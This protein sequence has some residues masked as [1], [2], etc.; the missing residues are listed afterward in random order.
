MKVAR[1]F[2]YGPP[3]TVQLVDVPRPEP[4][5][6]E[7]L[8][9]IHAA[10]VSSA[11]WRLRSGSIPRGF[12]TITRLVFGLRRL[13][14]PILGTEFSGT[15]WSLG[16]GAR[17]F[18]VGDP[19]IGFPGSEF[20]SHAEF[21]LMREDGRLVPKPAA[22][23]HPKAAALCF[24]GTT[25]LHY[26]RDRARLQAGQS[27]L[28]LGGAGSVGS[29]AIQL[30]QYFGASVSATSSADNLSL[31]R[32]LG[33]ASAFDY[34]VYDYS[35]GGLFYDVILDTVGAS[36][37]ASACKA[38]RP[39]GLYLAISADLMGTLRGLRRGPRG[40]RQ[41]AGPA[42]ERTADI[43]WL[44]NLAAEGRYRPVVDQCLPFHDI[45]QAHARVETGR[46]R[47]NVVLTMPEMNLTSSG[48]FTS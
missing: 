24:G 4:G 8:V 37:F 1:C 34:H 31:L 43:A 6:N 36:T 39:G 18:K 38:L 25:A 16:S 32:E 21:R 15:V 20:R 47:G 14:Q 12:G 23:S 5:N 28:I 9:R 44:A 26:L 30:A 33:A 17:R 46:K 11:D 45:V 2:R 35:G 41:M 48:A 22:L 27:I 13:R 19:V 3:E 29:A 40:Q 42:P 7:V 10:T